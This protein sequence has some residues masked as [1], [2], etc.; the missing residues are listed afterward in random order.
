M[1]SPFNTQSASRLT[2][3]TITGTA[4]GIYRTKDTYSGVN[5]DANIKY[6]RDHPEID[7]ES[8]IKPKLPLDF[9]GFS[10][11]FD[12]ENNQFVVILYPPYEKT[13]EKFSSWMDNAGLTDIS[14]F[15]IIED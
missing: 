3:P 15:K 6:L 7:A 2:L 4:P 8:Q 14:R 12:Y 1:P 11:D 10:V 13:M 5:E 9:N